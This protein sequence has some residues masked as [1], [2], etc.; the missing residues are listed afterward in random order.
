[1]TLSTAARCAIALLALAPAPLRAQTAAGRPATAAG[2]PARRPEWR[3][4]LGAGAVVGPPFR[5]LGSD[6][7]RAAVFPYV[8]IRWRDRLFLTPIE[9]LGVNLVAGPRLR[10]GVA[11]HVDA[12]RRSDDAPRLRGLGD[13][14][15]APVLVLFGDYDLPRVSYQTA[16]RR[17]LSSGGG[18]LVELSA[19]YRALPTR[20]LMLRVGPTVTWMDRHYATGRF[21][22]A[23]ARAAS[24]G[25]PAHL[26]GAGVRDVGVRGTVLGRLRG[27]WSVLTYL[28]ATRLVGGAARSPV[29]AR[30]T[31]GHVGTFL[32]YRF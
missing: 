15:A 25:L 28:E 4:T 32:T 17:R 24:S 13:V 5:D 16:A 26:P 31:N 27:R 29:V 14:S 21:G 19:A 7:I 6:E 10:L 20:R 22:V 1:M 11:G 30:A 12:G 18:L 8:D 23:P 2:A 9:G 3:V